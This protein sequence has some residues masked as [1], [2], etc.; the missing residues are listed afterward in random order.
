MAR[1]GLVA[2]LVLAALISLGSCEWFAFQASFD[3]DCTY[4]SRNLLS[5]E[6]WINNTCGRNLGVWCD[7]NNV[8]TAAC[9]SDQATSTCTSAMPAN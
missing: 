5:M 9:G 8:Y 2:L 3:V 1:E 4:S 7:A 6:L